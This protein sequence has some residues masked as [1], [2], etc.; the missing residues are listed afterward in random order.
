MPLPSELHAMRPIEPIEIE[1]DEPAELAGQAPPDWDLVPPT[2]LLVDEG[3][4]RGLSPK[5]LALIRRIVRT[6][7]WAKFRPPVCARVDG[8]LHVIDGQHTATAAASHGGIPVI[9][10]VVVAAPETVDRAR[11]F[12][13]HATDRLPTTIT[14]VHH[15]A[16]MA[17]DEDAV[18]IDRVCR[19]AGVDLVIY[20]PPRSAYRPGQTVALN[21]IRRLVNRR[22][23]MRARQILEALAK[24][25]LAPIS[26]DHI[27]AAE[28]LLCDPDLA[29]EVDAERITTGMR[30]MAARGYAEAKTLAATKNLTLW[31]SMVAVILKSRRARPKGGR[32]GDGAGTEGEAA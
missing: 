24:A 22:G 2:D 12:I 16:V 7:S 17:G 18:A 6:W 21:A 3:Y 9:P 23:A 27:R 5:S 25:G 10:V 32:P 20:P 26:A 11:A 31:R 4:Q 8:R 30:A 28:A 29:G 19:A 15:A 1:E 13:S 14:Q